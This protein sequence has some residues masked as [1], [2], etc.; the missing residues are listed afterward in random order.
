MLYLLY[1]LL[2]VLAVGGA[3][4][5]RKGKAWG[6]LLPIAAASAGMWLTLNTNRGPGPAQIDAGS[7]QRMAE[8]IGKAAAARLRNGSKVLVLGRTEIGQPSVLQAWSQGLGGGAGVQIE[9]T[10]A[11]VNETSGASVAGTY[12]LLV[13]EIGAVGTAVSLASISPNSPVILASSGDRPELDPAW[14][15]DE[16]RVLAHV[17]QRDGT[18]VSEP[19]NR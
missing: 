11:Q 15:I 13:I 9:V 6:A 10:L 18:L 5:M 16:S 17:F 2:T 4:L 3:L 7:E 14:Q 8:A 1:F 12:D 19:A